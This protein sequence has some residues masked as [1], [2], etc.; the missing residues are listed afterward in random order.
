MQSPLAPIL[1]FATPKLQLAV[2]SE[3]VEYIDETIVGILR[4]APLTIHLPIHDLPC[5]FDNVS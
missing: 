5:I 3:F 1:L 2:R 4:A